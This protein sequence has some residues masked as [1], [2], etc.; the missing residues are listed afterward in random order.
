MKYHGKDL[1]DSED[2]YNVYGEIMQKNV[3]MNARIKIYLGNS[4]LRYD[5]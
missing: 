5:T 2:F 1:I 4:P 3:S